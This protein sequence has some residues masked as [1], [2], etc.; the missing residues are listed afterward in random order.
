[1]SKLLRGSPKTLTTLRIYPEATATT[2]LSGDVLYPEAIF[3]P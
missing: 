3:D 1:M 2:G